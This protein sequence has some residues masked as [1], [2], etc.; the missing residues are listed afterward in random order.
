MDTFFIS[1]LFFPVYTDEEL[2]IIRNLSDFSNR[3]A[4]VWV[5]V[6]IVYVVV[7]IGVWA[8]FGR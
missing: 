5:S 2:R 1:R 6:A 4:E 7:R 8:L 3:F